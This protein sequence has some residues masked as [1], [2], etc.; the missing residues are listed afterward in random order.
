VRA[1]VTLFATSRVGDAAPLL[2]RAAKRLEPI[3]A[4]LARA[5]YLDAVLAAD[6]GQGYAAG[7][8]ILRRA[9][10]AFG[11]DMPA[12]PE[13]RWLSL[14]FGAAFH[15][16]DDEGF[17]VLSDRYLR[18]AREV[19]ALSELPLALFARIYALL[20]AGELTAAASA[21]QEMQAVLEA[22][23]VNLGP[24]GALGVAAMRGSASPHAA[25]SAASCPPL[26]T[27]PLPR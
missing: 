8:P 25:S 14:A 2:L 4:G 23:G 9:L 26:R 3:D 24:Y 22:T 12:G 16:W 19:G 21:A 5:T 13:L 6:F 27:L 10:Q 18:R 7:V 17:D 11:S 1:Q 20:F 15:I